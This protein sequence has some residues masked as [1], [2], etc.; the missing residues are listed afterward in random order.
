LPTEVIETLEIDAQGREALVLD[1]A[2][3]VLAA[4]SKSVRVVGFR[5]SMG[6]S[7]LSPREVARLRTLG[8]AT[9]AR[10]TGVFEGANDFRLGFRA[11][12][13]GAIVAP[14]FGVEA[15]LGGH[16]IAPSVSDLSIAS[17]GLAAGKTLT[18]EL[19][20]FTHVRSANA[21]GYGART[22]RALGRELGL[23]LVVTTGD[24]GFEP[25]GVGKVSISASRGP[26][27]GGGHAIDWK[28][29]GDLRAIHV[30][31]GGVRPR[32]L[33]MDRLEAELRE[34]LWEA[35]RIEPSVERVVTSGV[36]LGAFLQV[37]VECERGG[38]TFLEVVARTT[39]PLPLARRTVK[40]ALDFLDSGATSDE[41]T[42]ITTL[43]A[44]IAARATFELALTPSERLSAS[45]GLLRDIGGYIEE[46]E[47]P[48]L[49][50]LKTS[51]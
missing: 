9:G 41:I 19:R 2:L 7:G 15:D 33:Q 39:A 5:P 29:P 27:P 43:A 30:L 51:R 44:A 24:L 38:A 20:G 4:W 34:S 22:L 12:G 6:A 36:D 8:L 3:P 18:H 25:Q 14:S 23:D 31:M 50:L 11:E 49:V 40:R 13:G 10:A 37:D 28:K 42:G 48:G 16:P 1:I 46:E 21:Q 26:R 17:F 45:L 32:L 35:R 47:A